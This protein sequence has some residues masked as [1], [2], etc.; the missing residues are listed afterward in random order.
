M[1]KILFLAFI[2]CFGFALSSGA[3]SAE[4]AQVANANNYLV[5]AVPEKNGQ[6]VFEQTYAVPGKS[7]SELFAMLKTYA[8]SIVEGENKLPHSRI[9]EIS[10]EQGI[11]AASVEETLWFKR[12]ALVSDFASFS[13]QLLFEVSDAQFKVTMRR[14][15]YNYE[16]SDNAADNNVMLAEEWITDKEALKKNGTQLRRGTSKKLRIGT[17]N[18]KNEIFQGAGVACG[19]PTAHSGF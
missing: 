15:R 7:Q 5:G 1:K 9:T 11:I 6:V 3:Q 14:L 17:I 18:R 12:T 4:K 2:L 16:Q 8:Q 13:Y 10:P 19:L